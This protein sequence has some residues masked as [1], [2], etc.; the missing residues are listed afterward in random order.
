M[1]RQRSKQEQPITFAP[2]DLAALAEGRALATVRLPD[3]SRVSGELD[4]EFMVVPTDGWRSVPVPD[5][6]KAARDRDT[7][8]R[9]LEVGRRMTAGESVAATASALI[10]A[11]LMDPATDDGQIASRHRQVKKWRRRYRD[12]IEH[13]GM[14]RVTPMGVELID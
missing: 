8:K 14:L 1:T 11:G 9:V 3:G 6:A 13:G 10:A 12:W 7:A 2:F 5:A 4:T